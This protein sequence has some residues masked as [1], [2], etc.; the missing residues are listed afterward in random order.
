RFKQGT[1]KKIMY[2][3]DNLIN[4]N[5]IWESKEK[6]MS[7]VGITNTQTSNNTIAFAKRVLKRVLPILGLILKRLLQLSNV[8]NV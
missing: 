3:K 2:R 5:K 6:G 8:Q 7:E 4:T 1:F